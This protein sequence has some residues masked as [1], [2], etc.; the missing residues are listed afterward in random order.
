MLRALALG[1]R[2]VAGKPH[3]PEANGQTR[4][5]E[6][7]DCP[8]PP[9]QHGEGFGLGLG[10]GNV[11]SPSERQTTWS[12]PDCEVAVDVEA[13]DGLGGIGRTNGVSDPR[14]EE[15][16]P[17]EDQ[18]THHL[19][20]EIERCMLVLTSGGDMIHHMEKGKV[21][22]DVKRAVLQI[23]PHLSVSM[24]KV[25]P[26]EVHGQ[27]LLN[28][29]RALERPGSW[30]IGPHTTAG[31]CLEGTAFIA[32]NVSVKVSQSPAAV[33]LLSAVFVHMLAALRTVPAGDDGR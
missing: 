32:E 3:P 30:A 33:P 31:S 14:C 28:G 17:G 23:A 20:L 11:S 27:Y 6:R 12:S 16:D 10:Q 9:D 13:A 7:T 19:F 24:I 2:H 8:S 4:Q 21:S 29:R 22:L 25:H 15:A 1:M 26:I 5:E 18:V